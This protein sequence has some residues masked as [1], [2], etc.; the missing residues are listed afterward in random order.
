MAW[1]TICSSGYIVV[2]ISRTSSLSRMHYYARNCFL[3][4]KLDIEA[5]EKG[6]DRNGAD[7]RIRKAQVL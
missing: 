5:G 1:E 2:V 3:V 4:M 6:P 7:F